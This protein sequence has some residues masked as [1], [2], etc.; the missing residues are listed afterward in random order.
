MR[1]VFAVEGLAV[2]VEWWKGSVIW[3]DVVGDR[4]KWCEIL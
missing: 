1:T 2:K 3:V 4:Y